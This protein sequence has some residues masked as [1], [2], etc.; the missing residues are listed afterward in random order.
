[1]LAIRT[2]NQIIMGVHKHDID[3]NYGGD[4]FRFKTE[5]L[6]GFNKSPA[7]Y[8]QASGQWMPPS[9][10]GEAAPTGP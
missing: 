3:A 1:M 2:A 8:G 5:A 4:L 9:G 6:G 10:Q 7:P